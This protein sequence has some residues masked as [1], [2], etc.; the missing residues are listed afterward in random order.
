MK[1]FIGVA[2]GAPV[3]AAAGELSRELQARAAATAPLA[4]MSW[5]PP[6]RFHLTVLFIGHVTPPALEAVR[7]ALA[8][9][10]AEPRFDLAVAGAGVDSFIRLQREAFARVA[11]AVP[12][13]SERDA[14][15]HLTLARVKEPAGLRARALLEGKEGVMLGSIDV[16]AV[17][18]FESRPAAGVVH[19][20]PLMQTPLAPSRSAV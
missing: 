15:P 18:L 1:I 20:S 6:D 16:D 10:F 4:R 14:R 5:V 19:Y 2:A 12:L 13:V 11:R 8:R 17:T 3:T 9:P 7:A